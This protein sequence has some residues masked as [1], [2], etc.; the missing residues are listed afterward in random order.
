M[1]DNAQVDVA[2]LVESADT[3][4]Q[5]RAAADKEARAKRKR[6]KKRDANIRQLRAAKQRIK[7]QHG[8]SR[9][10]ALKVKVE[11]IEAAIAT[12]EKEAEEDGQ[13]LAGINAFRDLKDRAWRA[14]KSEMTHFGDVIGLLRSAVENG[15][16]RV[17]DLSEEADKAISEDA[18]K[19]DGIISVREKGNE[20]LYFFEGF[21]KKSID[22][23]LRALKQAKYR[24]T[25]TAKARSESRKAIED[26]SNDADAAFRMV[27][28]E[29]AIAVE[30]LPRNKGKGRPTDGH[31]LITIENG[32]L[33]LDDVVRGR[34]GN[35]LGYMV[36][37]ETRESLI[38]GTW[39]RGK[40][41]RRL[42]LQLKFADKGEQS[43]G[44]R[45]RQGKVVASFGGEE[46]S[47]PT[48]AGNAELAAFAKTL[49]EA[50]VTDDTSVPEV[51]AEAPEP[52][53][54]TADEQSDLVATLVEQF[55]ASEAA[56]RLAVEH[57]DDPAALLG[58]IEGTGKRKGQRITVNDVRRAGKAA[59][60]S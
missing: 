48:L 15:N 16:A 8:W 58:S 31:L 7:D 2:A 4:V 6:A 40:L 42:F 43:S 57:S 24:A 35:L 13:S 59:K 38:G 54:N 21:E 1:S 41:P 29:Y 55:E 23:L 5:E 37:E 27:D 3:V 10:P 20:M 22:S 46:N 44:R 39:G 56:A 28:G 32:M 19:Q 26:R 51:V 36:D 9:D 60:R 47:S 53:E 45:G 49:A 12:I 52:T 11:E 17:L 14:A 50:D 30:L 33:T 25:L 18:S 34:S